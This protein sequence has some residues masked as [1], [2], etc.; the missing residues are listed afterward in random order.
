MSGFLSRDKQDGSQNI[1]S[2]SL[3]SLARQ[4][5]TI[6]ICLLCVVTVFDILNR[7]QG[8]SL[9]LRALQAFPLVHF[10]RC[11]R[12]FIE[13]NALI[14]R[15][16]RYVRRRRQFLALMSSLSLSLSLWCI[17]QMRSTRYSGVGR[18]GNMCTHD[19]RYG[20]I[21]LS[22]SLSIPRWI[23]NI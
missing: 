12:K 16:R 14:G 22:L 18:T 17:E 1:F 13:F 5:T 11:L 23:V 4:R 15:Q 7:R 6:S 21:S 19:S 2:P 3:A 20:S 9:A 8:S 10:R